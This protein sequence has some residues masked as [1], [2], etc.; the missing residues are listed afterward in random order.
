MLVHV[1]VDVNA[2]M[3]ADMSAGVDMDVHEHLLV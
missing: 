3:H 2:E 1:G